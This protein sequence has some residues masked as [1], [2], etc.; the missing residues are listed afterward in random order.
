M[1]TDYTGLA[2]TYEFTSKNG[3]APVSG[4]ITAGTASVELEAGTWDLLVS[5]K[6]NDTAVLEG[7]VPGIKIQAG[8]K[9]AVSVNMAAVTE[10]GTG[11]G[12]LTYSVTFPA[13]VTKG[14]LT[15]YR[16]ADETLLDAV[17]VSAEGAAGTFGDLPA[18]YYR[19]A[20]DLYKQDG[21]FHQTEIAQI[22]PGLTTAAEYALTDGDFTPATVVDA[23][24]TTLGA[25]LAGVSDLPSN[26]NNLYFLSD[27]NE[28]LAAASVLNENG[29]VT[30]AID[31]GGRTVTL[32][33]KGSLITV[34]SNVTLS[35][36]NI[37]LQGRGN[38]ESDPANDAA[39]V[40]VESGGKLELGTGAS[41]TGNKRS[42]PYGGG[43]SVIGAFTMNG[44][45]ISGNTAASNGGGVY[46]FTSGTFTM[47]GGK[48]SGNKTSSNSSYG[49]GVYAAGAFTM[50][51][52]EIS[53]NTAVYQGGGVYFS[54][55]ETFT[56]S[57][58]KISGNTTSDSSGG[59]VYVASGTFNMSGGEIS[60][61]RASSSGGGGV[62][63]Y[64]G[65]TF[66]MSGGKI[67]GNT[68]ASSGGGVYFDG[69]TFTMNNGEISRNTANSNSPSRGGGGVFVVSGTFTMN[70]GEISGNTAASSGGG[71]YVVSGT[72]T[73]NNGEISGNTA[74]TSGGGVY[75]SSYG[76]LDMSGGKISGNM[77]ASGGGVYVDRRTFTKTGGGV[78]YGDNAS[79]A[80]KNTATD[81]AN[82]GKNGHAVLYVGSNSGYPFTSTY[83]YRNA[84]L[85]TGDDIS[86]DGVTADSPGAFDGSR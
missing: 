76:T 72:F 19:V 85:D 51:G 50:N 81:S 77:G 16:W 78:I 79:E 63:V 37:T 18:G 6:A 25:I 47:N 32:D 21:V 70:N 48:I 15:V 17:D 62:S 9:E 83:F 7:K 13:A 31:G 43:V 2:Y 84:T 42:T 69:K 12:T 57:G 73:M 58:G 39:L 28:T 52:G 67:S 86:T 35:L 46:V 1:P 44:G 59:G 61:N 36:R 38:G 68:A 4:P 23:P 30:L 60:D 64:S 5:G 66:T 8:E 34:G 54:S 24:D 3:K 26:A 14:T 20:L 53:G 55:N 29:P 75:V 41:I 56:M 27:G 40:S 71:V 11:T 33:G 49:G 22:Y 82:S 65:G 74:A 80:N 10:S 45:E